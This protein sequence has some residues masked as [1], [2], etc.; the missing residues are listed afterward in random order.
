MLAWLLHDTSA[1]QQ[2]GCVRK[3][4]AFS[5]HRIDHEQHA[6]SP[7]QRSHAP[8][9]KETGVTGLAGTLALLPNQAWHRQGS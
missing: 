3:F 6:Q 8:P 2:S 1:A 7:H 5:L 9:G 4:G